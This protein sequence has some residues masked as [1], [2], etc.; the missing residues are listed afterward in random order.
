[1][2]TSSILGGE[3]A[4]PYPQ[5]RDVGSLGPSDSSD[6][7]SDVAN[8]PP[9]GIAG[10]VGSTASA[11]SDAAGTGERSTATPADAP[12]DNRDIEPDSVV[13]NPDESGVRGSTQDE[14]ESVED[15]IDSESDAPDD[16]PATS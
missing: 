5:G 6:S 9:P 14:T 8:V 4:T 13:D 16:D 1:M 12:L 3:R 2:A 11:D 10:S 7:G 15:L